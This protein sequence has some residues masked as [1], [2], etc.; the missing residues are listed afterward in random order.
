MAMLKKL[1]FLP[2]VQS[3]VLLATTINPDSACACS[4]ASQTV[5]EA[6]NSSDAIF[7]GRVVEVQKDADSDSVS[8]RSNTVRL[9]VVR[10]WK[11]V[12]EEKLTVRTA[13]NDAGCGY[14]FRANQSYLV[15]ANSSRAGLR[16]GLCGRTK[17]IEQAKEDLDVL[18]MGEVPVSAQLPQDEKRV[19]QPP[20]PPA[21][22]AG[23]AS[24]D[25]IASEDADKGTLVF[26]L[27]I[28][29]FYLVR[30]RSRQRRCI[31][32]DFT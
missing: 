27:T 1:V 22:Q 29:V 14:P 17:P 18:G 11:G 12:G 30:N 26:W 9:R 21:E 31:R 28:L 25:L 13:T 24:C 4:C 5:E 6:I 3:L 20:N 10:S 8:T 2:I 7:E 32:T 16:V 23:C 15:Y 19:L